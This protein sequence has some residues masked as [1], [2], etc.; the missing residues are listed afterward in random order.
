MTQRSVTHATFCIERTF[1][2]PPARVFAA[3][4]SL[5][6]KSQWFTGA[7]GWISTDREFDFR[8]GGREVSKVGPPGGPM[9]IFEARYWDIVPNERVVFSYDMHL[10]ETRISVSLTTIELKP[11]GA[12]AALSFTEQG[13]FLDG[14]DDPKGRE[15]GTRRL[16]NALEASLKI[17]VA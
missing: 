15:D 12:G 17:A 7:P 13:A 5:E 8:V 14:F 3:F 4:A 10:D 16:L 9:H 11:S 2:A 1:D 6:A